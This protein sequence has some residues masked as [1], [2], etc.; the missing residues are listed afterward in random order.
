M[1]IRPFPFLRC[2]VLV[3]IFVGLV[4]LAQAHEAAE[5]FH[6]DVTTEAK[7][8]THLEFQNDP[9]NF[10]FAVVSDR[11]GGPRD[12][13]FQ[14]AVK[15][16]N[17]MMPEFVISV[18]DLIKG[19]SAN[20]RTNHAEWDEF[21]GWVEPLKMPF[22]FAAGN[23]D[24]QMKW[25]EG[26]VQPEE[27][28]AAWQERFGPTHYSF[29]YKNVLFVVLFT[30]D[31]AERVIEDEQV[32]YFEQTMAEHP[33]VRW[34]F[35]ILHH[36]LWAYPHESG[37]GRIEAALQGRKHTVLAGHHHRYVHFDRNDTD[38]IILASTGGSSGMRGQAFGEFDHF[39]WFTMTDEGPVMA[40]LDL[41]G[42]MPADVSKLKSVD[43][44]RGLEESAAVETR[45]LLSTD[46]KGDVVAGS[47]FL[48]LHNRS[49]K[50][51]RI[52]GEFNHSHA[53]HPEP[54]RIE[55]VMAPHAT[56]VVE[57]ALTV[58]QP[59]TEADGLRLDFEATFDLDRIDVEGLQI[60]KTTSIPLV[61]GS[62]DVFVTESREFVGR[63]E[64]MPLRDDDSRDIRYTLDGSEPEA[65]SAR[66]TEPLVV[67]NS[68]LLK[69]RL[70]TSAGL[71]GPVDTLELIKV[72][73]GPGLLARYYER[74]R[75]KGDVNSM[76][77]FTGLLPTLTRRVTNFDLAQ[78]ARRETDFAVVFHGW[79]P[80][81]EAGNYGFH[82]GSADGA[83]LLIN[84]DD[85]VKDVIKHGKQETAG[86]VQLPV[87]R[88][89]IELR[90]FQANRYSFLQV[91]YTPPSGKRQ[92]IPDTALSFDGE[93]R[94]LFDSNP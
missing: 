39:S 27:M 6:S 85:V 14:D 63:T 76:P 55:A 82:V 61:S 64:V 47:A 93:S 11:T 36:P 16:L 79:L 44:V 33:E 74:E 21:M 87:G 90:F 4:G 8:W 5:H 65:A 12:G 50:P 77:V 10:Q 72:A 49:K 54:G 28:L 1:K 56:K 83:H 22:F 86:F 9:D 30:N 75:G 46:A 41:A 84:G 73:A 38:Y 81:T 52:A 35:V 67:T 66:L 37:F 58:M 18:G 19:T 92:P 17:W 60:S 7:P 34:T 70:F 51:L 43:W 71:A 78:V 32:A 23:H 88:H 53:V 3:G 89:A 48:E 45:V 15:K 57:V 59:F 80:V 20:A 69:A 68:T 40:N 91:D 13:V 29:V 24:I 94:P 26:R 42:I 31:G 2:F 25:I 62:A